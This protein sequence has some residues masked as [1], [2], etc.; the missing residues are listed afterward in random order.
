VS[1]TGATANWVFGNPIAPTRVEI[2]PV[3]QPPSEWSVITINGGLQSREFTG[4]T[5]TTRYEW[6]V[7]HVLGALLSDYLGP[8]AATTFI[9]TAATQLLAAPP[10]SPA[11]S[12]AFSDVGFTDITVSW[13]AAVAGQLSVVAIAGPLTTPP[14]EADYAAFSYAA[15]VSSAVQRITASGLY[16]VRVRYEPVDPASVFSPSAWA[17]PTQ[18][19]VTVFAP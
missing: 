10:S 9:T 12:I 17:G 14:D 7:A 8:S 15:G 6:R 3:T 11:I 2:R 18:A 16:W 5:P 4:L 1:A 19:I 13:A